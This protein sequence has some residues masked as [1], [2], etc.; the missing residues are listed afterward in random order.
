LLLLFALKW[1]LG[2]TLVA[3]AALGAATTMLG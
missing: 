1:N 2:R 3:C